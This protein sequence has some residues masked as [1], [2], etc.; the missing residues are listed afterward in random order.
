MA[1]LIAHNSEH[2]ETIFQ[3]LGDKENDITR[4]IAW[5]M[6][7]CPSFLDL[8]IK[9]LGLTCNVENVEIRYQQFEK[10]GSENSYTDLEITDGKN[11]HLILEAKRGWILPGKN[12]LVKYADRS[13]FKNSRIPIKN[14][15][16]VT[17]SECSNEYANRYLPLKET[18]DGISITHFSWKK[19]HKLAN[20]S[21]ASAK[22]V[23]KHLLDEFSVYIGGLMT[24]QNKTSNYVYVVS[25][26]SSIIT[27]AGCSCI[28]LVE[29][30]GH[31]HC[32]VGNGWPKE[33]PN[34]IGFR[35]G[36]RLQAIHHIEGYRITKNIHDVIDIMPNEE[37][38]KDHFIFDLGPAIIPSK[39]VK[40]GNLF[41]NGRVWAMID[42]LLTCDTISEAR[43]LSQKRQKGE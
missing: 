7:Q 22:N 34:Y 28:E 1:I 16:I 5:T 43:D 8:F 19:L 14:K 26:S 24:T 4:A 10:I 29:K 35:Y 9:A 6:K 33:A 18:D 39:I 17:L 36:G 12:Q 37:L 31:Y 38:D 27:A 40:T 41:R 25:L 15:R 32:P 21:R 3:L 20:E 23:E 13:S 11:I 2:I 30:T 42:T